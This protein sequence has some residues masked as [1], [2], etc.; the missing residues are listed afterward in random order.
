MHRGPAL[1]IAFVVGA[2]SA[3]ALGPDSDLAR[4]MRAQ[5]RQAAERAIAQAT[6]QIESAAIDDKQ[7]AAAFRARGL[8]RS[9]LGQYAEAA[10]DLSRA[11]ELDP[12]NPLYYEDRAIAHLKLREFRQ[13]DLDLEMALGLDRHRPAAQR[14][15]GRLAFYR[16]DYEAAAQAFTRLARE[17]EGQVFVY[18]VLWLELAIR[19]GSLKR[20]SQL[21]LAEQVAGAGGWPAP[22]VQMYRGAVQ[23]EQAIA[24][25]TAVDPRVSL[26]QQ[27]E[28]YFYAGQVYL[29]GQQPQ[30]AK[31]AFEAAVATGVTDFLEYDWAVRELELMAEQ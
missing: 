7:V 13:A 8:A 11:V 19:R 25:A 24:A 1:L 23:P 31:A 16:G 9:R 27:C 14:E 4:Q 5:Q 12:F 15:K 17:A 20:P 18:S 29:I 6:L 10:M 2:S 28:A 30:Q 26:G 22:L 3:W 21:A